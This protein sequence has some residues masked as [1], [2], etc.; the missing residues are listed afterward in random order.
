MEAAAH[1][2]ASRAG[3][4]AA[5]KSVSPYRIRVYRSLSRLPVRSGRGGENEGHEATRAIGRESAGERTAGWRAVAGEIGGR[6]WA[7]KM[8][9][10]R[11][12]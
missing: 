10:R 4:I 1:R 3:P 6:E 5:S 9:T 2:G 7:K 11:S 12:R 8:D